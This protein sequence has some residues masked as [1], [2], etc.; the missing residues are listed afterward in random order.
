ERVGEGVSSVEAPAPTESAV[1]AELLCVSA[2]FPDAPGSPVGVAV[3][4]VFGHTAWL[5]GLV[6]DISHRRMGIA[7]Q[8][9]AQW[10]YQ[11]ADRGAVVALCA[12]SSA[13]GRDESGRG[14]D[15]LEELGFTPVGSHLVRQLQ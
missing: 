11:S 12:R 13:A 4:R 1:G 8:V 15:V 14:L 9:L 5:D 3:G 6:T 2:E 7:R 10:C